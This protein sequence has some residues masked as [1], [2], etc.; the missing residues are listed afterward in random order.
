MLRPTASAAL[1]YQMLGRGLR[2]D[3]N[4]SDCLVLDL[5][6]NIEFHGPIDTLNKRI[7]NRQRPKEEEPGEVPMKQCPSCEEFVHAAVKICPHCDF[8]FP[9]AAIPHAD[10]ATDLSPLSGCDT[11]CVE[12]V[13]YLLQAGKDGKPKTI[14]TIY[15]LVNAPEITIWLASDPSSHSFAHNKWK[16]WL[17]AQRLL[18]DPPKMVEVKDWLPWL[19]KNVKLPISITYTNDGSRFKEILQFNHED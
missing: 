1:Y 12:G 16:R 8:K 10:T 17:V 4:K 2:I 15:K 18:S 7:T 6:G 11:H 3:P 19:R 5:A 14:K 13:L 9:E